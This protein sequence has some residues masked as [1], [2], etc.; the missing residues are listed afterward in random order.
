MDKSIRKDKDNAQSFAAR[1]KEIRLQANLSRTEVAEKL[2][3]A[4]STYGNWEQGRRSPDICEI[5]KLLEV[6]EIDANEL[7]DIN[8]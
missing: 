7:F 6:F 1:L 4:L 8:L 5:Y 3:V 2:G